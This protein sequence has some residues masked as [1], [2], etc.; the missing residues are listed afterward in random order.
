[1]VPES[2]WCNIKIAWPNYSAVLDRGFE[3]KWRVEK[4]RKGFFVEKWLHVEYAPLTVF[5]N[6]F[7]SE[8]FTS[9]YSDNITQFFHKSLLY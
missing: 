9:G 1:M 3:E 4:F 6:K 8:V 2:L 5:K 7:Q